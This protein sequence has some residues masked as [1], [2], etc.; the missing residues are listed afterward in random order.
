MLDS[1]EGDDDRFVAGMKRP[2]VCAVVC[3]IAIAFSIEAIVA[4]WGERLPVEAFF[5]ELVAR[6]F[7][8]GVPLGSLGGGLW[9]GI[10]VFE[11]TGSRWLGWIGGISLFAAIGLGGV[12]LQLKLPSVD[13]RVER[14]RTNS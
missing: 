3:I 6:I 9:G 13:W 1:V 4:V 7:Y 11:K 14:L 2:L 12:M 10:K 5:E 8:Y